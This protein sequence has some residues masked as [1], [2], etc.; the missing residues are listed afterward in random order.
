MP[1][2]VR[3]DTPGTRAYQEICSSSFRLHGNR[4]P[5]NT[6]TA[7]QSYTTRLLHPFYQPIPAQRGC[8]RAHN[9]NGSSIPLAWDLSA[10]FLHFLRN[11]GNN[12]DAGFYHF[13]LHVMRSTSPVHTDVRFHGSDIA[14][15]V[16]LPVARRSAT[17]SRAR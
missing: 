4:I 15:R 13:P 6:V 5:A 1:L 16:P 14:S 3:A 7:S 9:L 17:S 2:R 10:R 8:C 11:A 12:S